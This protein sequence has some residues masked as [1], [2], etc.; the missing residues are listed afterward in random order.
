MGLAR[1]GASVVLTGRQEGPLDDSCS[2]IRQQLRQDKLEDVEK[3]ACYRAC[4]VTKYEGLPR[5]VQDAELLTGI[6]PT[7]LVNNAGVNV[8][9]TADDLTSEHWQQSFELMLTAPFMLTR[10]LSKNMKARQHGRVITIASLQSFRAF[11]DSLP[12]ATAKTGV[13]GLSR[14]LSEAYAPPHGYH[15]VTCNAIA[16]GYVKTKLTA[17]VFAD[18]ERSRRLADATLLGRNSVPSDLVG[19]TVFLASPSASYITGQTLSVDGGFT[20]LGM[21]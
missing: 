13:L 15:N 11:P 10:A 1:A 20:A 12:Y 3:R 14:A 17:S 18:I 4:D 6:A 5:F 2:A 19:A 21:R 7:I 8:R 9:Q 16:P